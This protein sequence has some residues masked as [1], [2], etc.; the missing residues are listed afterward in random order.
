MDY[1]LKIGNYSESEINICLR[2]NFLDRFIIMIMLYIY[3][4]VFVNVMYFCVYFIRFH[5]IASIL[6]LIA[7]NIFCQRCTGVRL[8]LLNLIIG[9]RLLHDYYRWSLVRV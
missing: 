6:Y 2:L 7:Y 3:I 8:Y 1:I 9:D 4:Y 5:R